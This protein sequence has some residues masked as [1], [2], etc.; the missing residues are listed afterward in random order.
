[1]RAM[2]QGDLAFFYHSN[3]KVPGIAGTMEIVK[4][5]SVDGKEDCLVL[6]SA[7]TDHVPQNP[8][9]TKPILIT[10]QSLIARIQSGRLCTLNL[11]A[12]SKS[13]FPWRS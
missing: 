10:T 9:L 1:M 11:E 13:S 3:C 12:N 6:I 7:Q 8:H 2:K 4:E 5:H